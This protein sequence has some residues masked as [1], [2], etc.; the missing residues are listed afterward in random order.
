MNIS[1][2]SY[3]NIL[4]SIFIIN[5]NIHTQ[6]INIA[7]TYNINITPIFIQT[8]EHVKHVCNNIYITVI[9][10]FRCIINLIRLIHIIKKV[11]FVRVSFIQTNYKTK[12]TQIKHNITAMFHVKQLSLTAVNNILNNNNNPQSAINKQSN[13]TY[14]RFK[15]HTG[16][17]GNQIKLG[18]NVTNNIGQIFIEK[19][20]RLI[21][22]VLLRNVCM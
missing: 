3:N 15:G 11:N 4:L 7:Y 13:I 8:Y 20:E 10:L 2:T 21:Q 17:C 1:I 12:D 18:L 5:R 16:V 14:Q 6:P 19:L 22:L 9:G